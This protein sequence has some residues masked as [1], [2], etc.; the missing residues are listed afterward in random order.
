MEGSVIA[1]AR[2]TLAWASFNLQGSSRPAVRN[3]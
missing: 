1:R 2:L 3:C